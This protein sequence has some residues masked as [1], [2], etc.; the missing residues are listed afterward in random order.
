M[1]VIVRLDGEGIGVF[2]VSDTVVC[3]VEVSRAVP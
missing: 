2:V 1:C 3:G